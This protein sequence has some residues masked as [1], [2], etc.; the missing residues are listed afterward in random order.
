VLVTIDTSDSFVYVGVGNRCLLLSTVSDWPPAEGTTRPVGDFA[1]TLRALL[2][3]R[4]LSQAELARRVGVSAQAVS[5]WFAAG[6]TPTRENV[7]LIEDE[8]A[9]EPRGSL[10]SLAGYST[11]GLAAEVTVESAIRADRGLDPEDKRVL[12]RILRLA[13]ERHPE[14]G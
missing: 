3:E 14:P 12:L 13:R 5:G 7:E 11:N 8:L 10:I 2:Q 1:E 4:H 6:N 9:V